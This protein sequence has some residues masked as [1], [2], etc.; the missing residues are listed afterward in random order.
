VPEIRQGL[1]WPASAYQHDGLQTM[2]QIDLFH[3]HVVQV[4]FGVDREEGVRRAH[5]DSALT[6][7][8]L[9]MFRAS[10]LGIIGLLYVAIIFLIPP[11]EIVQVQYYA[12]PDTLQAWSDDAVML[13]RQ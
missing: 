7:E 4:E 9:S 8:L 2:M 5:D 12:L 3:G 10:S 1:D 13:L 11:F 6:K